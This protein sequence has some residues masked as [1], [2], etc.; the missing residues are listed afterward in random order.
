MCLDAF[1]FLRP[2]QFED[3]MKRRQLA[4]M[5]QG[6]VPE[7]QRLVRGF[8]A[9]SGAK[10]LKFIR[11]ALRKWCQPQYA[12][13]FRFRCMFSQLNIVDTTRF[14]AIAQVYNPDRSLRNYSCHIFSCCDA[15]SFSL[16]SLCFFVYFSLSLSLL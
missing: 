2:T 12:S 10:R 14:E 7:L 8:L 16:A 6:S 5:M 3:R 11:S 15:L 9:R 13:E 1:L 4:L